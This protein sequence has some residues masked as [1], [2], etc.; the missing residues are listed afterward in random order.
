MRDTVS[1]GLAAAG[2]DVVLAAAT[3]PELFD[4]LPA[5]QPEV[6]LVDLRLDDAHGSPT[7]DGGAVLRR[8]R[9]DFPAIRALVLSADQRVETIAKCEELGAWGF[10]SKVRTDTDE[11]VFAVRRVASGFR[12]LGHRAGAPPALAPANPSRG[13]LES[14]SPRER[15][16]LSF[17]SVGA[18]NLKIAS[19][20]G[21]T[22]RT[23]RAHVCSLYRKLGA[24]NRTQ[25]AL[26]ARKLGVLSPVG[27]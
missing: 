26:L 19:N 4:A 8:L 12:Y 7:M 17:I 9:A 3:I 14:V 5:R 13:L 15:E 10:L 27:F 24:E 25:L 18:D 2:V 22:E 20:L 23:V 11:L 6:I 1:L 16:V 21:I